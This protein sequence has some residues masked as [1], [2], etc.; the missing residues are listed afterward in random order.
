MHGLDK[1]QDEWTT[2]TKSS[3][4][5][6]NKEDTCMV[7]TNGRRPKKRK[8]LKIKIIIILKTKCL[9]TNYFKQNNFN[10]CQWGRT[11]NVAGE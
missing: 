10:E 6:I 8:V 1:C 7:W 2:N 4:N 11:C 5:N 3:S 9:K